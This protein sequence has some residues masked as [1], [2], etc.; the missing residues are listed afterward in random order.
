MCAFPSYD[1]KNLISCKQK[2]TQSS[3]VGDMLSLLATMSSPHSSGY[4]FLDVDPG[5]ASQDLTKNKI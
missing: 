3:P 1:F 4:V 2:S 5:M